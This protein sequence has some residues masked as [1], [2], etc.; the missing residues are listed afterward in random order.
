L[1]L[2]D[3]RITQWRGYNHSAKKAKLEAKRKKNKPQTQT[4]HNLGLNNLSQ[5]LNNPP[6]ELNNLSQGLNNLSESPKPPSDIASKSPQ[7]IT[8]YSNYLYVSNTNTQFFDNEVEIQLSE[9]DFE[10]SSEEQE[11]IQEAITESLLINDDPIFR[12]CSIPETN[13]GQIEELES[14]ED[15]GIDGFNFNY[16]ELGKNKDFQEWLARKWKAKYPDI[17]SM[18]EAIANVKAYFIN[19][20]EKIMIRWEEYQ[21][22]KK[23]RIDAQDLLLNNYNNNS[24]NIYSDQYGRSV[25]VNDYTGYHQKLEEEKPNPKVAQMMKDFLANF[26]GGRR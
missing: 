14:I 3:Y 22:E 17:T 24:V 11:E 19:Q 7:T 21:A 5:G 9:D 10:I 6:Y 16:G 18:H 13:R 20:P 12:D 4:E 23:Q 2:Y 26:Q 15:K 8:D 25:K 1:E